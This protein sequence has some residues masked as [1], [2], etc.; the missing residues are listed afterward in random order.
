MFCDVAVDGFVGMRAG[1]FLKRSTNKREGITTMEFT[2]QHRSGKSV[3]LRPI[4]RHDDSR[5]SSSSA[6]GGHL[7]HRR[8]A[9]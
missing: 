7:D 4:R 6:I 9:R 8:N 1:V 5:Q 3:L 2:T